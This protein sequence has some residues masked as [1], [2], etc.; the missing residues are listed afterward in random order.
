MPD[1]TTNI[2]ASIFN[3]ENGN[4]V[5]NVDH[6]DEVIVIDSSNTRLGIGTPN[7]SCSLDVSGTIYALNMLI[8]ND[9]SANVIY[10]ISDLCYNDVS[11]QDYRVLNIK[12]LREMIEETPI[13]SESGSA[14]GSSDN[15]FFFFQAKP[16]PP[17]Y[18]NGYYSYPFFDTPY[19][20]EY[21][22]QNPNN[23]KF[24]F[25]T[26]TSLNNLKEKL[27]KG[28]KLFF[29]IP[30]RM[31]INWNYNLP[32]D[33]SQN[34]ISLYNNLKIDYRST[35]NNGSDSADLQ[36]NITS[37]QDEHWINIFNIDF[38]NY[39]PSSNPNYKNDLCMN[40]I[41]DISLNSGSSTDSSSILIIENSFNIIYNYGN[42]NE[43]PIFTINKIYQFRI[44]LENNSTFDISLIPGILLDHK[45]NQYNESIFS[46]EIQNNY[47][48]FPGTSNEYFATLPRGNPNAPTNL[49]FTYP[50]DQS[51]NLNKTIIDFCMNL[52][53][54]DSNDTILFPI[55]LKNN[56]IVFT[57][58]F[59]GKEISD[60][61][62]GVQYDDSNPYVAKSLL[63]I[64]ISSLDSSN[65]F[66]SKTINNLN[67]GLL[68]EYIYDV[69]NFGVYFYDKSNNITYQ[70]NTMSNSDISS[71]LQISHP[72]RSQVNNNFTYFIHEY[73]DNIFKS[74]NLNYFNS[75]ISFEQVYWR[76]NSSNGTLEYFNFYN[77]DDRIIIDYSNVKIVM[78]I[79]GNYIDTS[80]E[81]Y[82]IDLLDTSLNNII[83]SINSYYNN[84][85]HEDLSYS[86]YNLGFHHISNFDNDI[87]DFSS[88]NIYHFIESNV[89]IL[90]IC[91][92]N[93]IFSGYYFGNDL[94]GLF[95]ICFTFF[96]A[97]NI[98]TEDN[99]NIYVIPS[100]KQQF[101]DGKISDASG[102]YR[103]YKR[104]ENLTKEFIIDSSLIDN[105]VNNVAIN[106]GT[107]FGLTSY[108]P[109]QNFYIETSFNVIINGLNEYIKPSNNE[110][111]N[112]YIDI[113]NT[114]NITENIIDNSNTNKMIYWKD[115]NLNTANYIFDFSFNPY[116]N[117]VTITSGS[118]TNDLS[119]VV[120]IS[121]ELYNN[122][123]SP[124]N[125]HHGFSSSPNYIELS[126]NYFW[127][128][129]KLT[130][131]NS[132]FIN[133]HISIYT[134]NSSFI[135]DQGVNIISYDFNQSLKGFDNLPIFRNGLFYGPNNSS[136]Y[137]NYSIYYGNKSSE[138]D[139]TDLNTEGI[140]ISVNIPQQQGWFFNASSIT[141][142]Y[143]YKVLIFKIIG[144]SNSKSLLKITNVSHYVAPD[145]L[146]YMHISN[147]RPERANNAW[148]NCNIRNDSVINSNAPNNTNLSANQ[149][150]TATHLFI[151]LP[152][153][154]IYSDEIID[155]IFLIKENTIFNLDGIN[156][157]FSN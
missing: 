66:I 116:K 43:N 106:L 131:I 152:G 110:F 148:F 146:Y 6:E 1:N 26:D 100:I 126:N 61:K 39:D 151:K 121:L 137:I 2:I 20:S 84:T 157:E 24:Q 7:P 128:T 13:G 14:S 51:N 79:S 78:G 122:I 40:F 3:I 37:I 94:S 88:D 142:N 120:D 15:F 140:D 36:N 18:L 63:L 41:L 27:I 141:T 98:F 130:D 155:I 147:R 149:G 8:Q 17:I 132:N 138:F 123:F 28:L 95:D 45:Q 143:K 115:N 54:A 42:L 53:Y 68:P 99:S 25:G 57:L 124:N 119:Y 74:K 96:D 11:N 49:T 127:D 90:D 134:I 58:D 67:Y 9:I 113:S 16:W 102:I 150:S 117:Y 32:S 144:G 59:I 89:N 10:S 30:P 93:N 69:S 145:I 19:Y 65:Q 29:K 104:N 111:G 82:G 101:L 81:S 22:T 76:S 114:T 23:F 135:A 107:Y 80:N 91:S 103:I 64:D 129:T 21:N 109:S 70:T 85:F 97:N 136:I 35:D 153:G 112:I 60:F 92:T 4:N 105:S 44:Y 52:P 38:R 72:Y 108:R 118:L 133:S 86:L 77:N 62:K 56:N 48:Y 12:Q 55:L 47:L 73:T 139:Y 46:S 156:Y 125:S 50:V 33:G 71:S 31:F 34:Y 83:F 154:L 75:S 5:V 87:L